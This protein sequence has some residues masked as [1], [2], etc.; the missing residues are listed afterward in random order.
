MCGTPYYLSPE[1][2]TGQPYSFAVD[3]WA[4]GC[5]FFELI[6]LHKPFIG[7]KPREVFDAI[8]RNAPSHVH[9][10]CRHGC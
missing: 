2:V 10:V 4:L 5:V 7:D 1:Q 8:A 9:M 6:S 3:A